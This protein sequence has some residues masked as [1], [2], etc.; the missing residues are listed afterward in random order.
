MWSSPR[1]IGDV[2]VDEPAIAGRALVDAELDEAAEGDGVRLKA[3]RGKVR[4]QR[5]RGTEGPL[6]AKAGEGIK[7]RVWVGMRVKAA[8]AAPA[9]GGKAVA[10]E[11]FE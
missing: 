5:E 8:A 7:K 1:V 4:E 6:D 9:S 10:R 11:T 3:R 2:A